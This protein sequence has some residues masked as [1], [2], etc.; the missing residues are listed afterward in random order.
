MAWQTSVGMGG[1]GGSA[2]VGSDVGGSAGGQAQG[3]EYTL[4]GT[5]IEVELQQQ[6]SPLQ[7]EWMR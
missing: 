3:T 5:D 7:V 1:S 4:Q 6:L 2:S